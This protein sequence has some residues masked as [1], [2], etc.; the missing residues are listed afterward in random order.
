MK[1]SLKQF[2]QNKFFRFLLVGSCS[3]AID[4]VIY[5]LFSLRIQINIAKTI[6]ML[7]ASVFSY[8]A[9]KL[10]TFQDTHKTN[11]GYL[12][13]FYIVFVLNLA[14]NIWV[15][16]IC[17]NSSENKVLSFVFATAVGMTLNY[18]GQRFFVFRK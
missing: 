3:T 8:A 9:N 16:Y 1:D 12:I 14:T 4:F 5:M 18:L 15:N 11:V 17:Y 13:R 6:S 2:L 10:F 7:M